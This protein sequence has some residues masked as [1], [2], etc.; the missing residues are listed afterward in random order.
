MKNEHATKNGHHKGHE[1]IYKDTDDHKHNTH[2]RT[3]Q[4]SGHPPQKYHQQQQNHY[5][6]QHNYQGA[7]SHQKQFSRPNVGIRAR[8]QEQVRPHS[9]RSIPYPSPL[10]SPAPAAPE[11]IPPT[12][13][14]EKSEYEP[15]VPPDLPSPGFVPK[16]YEMRTFFCGEGAVQAIGTPLR[17]QFWARCCRN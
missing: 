15:M 11:P 14:Y 6:P 12:G 1:T 16:P 3:A 13:S 4:Q 2:Y 9:V 10:P 17:S 5:Y 7:Y 8:G